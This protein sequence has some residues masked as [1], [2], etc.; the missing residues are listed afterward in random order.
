MR[1]CS[2][3]L[4]E[5]TRSRARSI[6]AVSPRAFVLVHPPPP[7][8]PAA[9]QIPPSSAHPP[10]L[11]PPRFSFPYLPHFQQFTCLI[12]LLL[13][14]SDGVLELLGR[15]LRPAGIFTPWIWCSS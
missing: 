9:C 11:A 15:V 8:S 3:S 4:L 12:S 5:C 1:R 7:S 14:N 6:S 2:R 10:R 13:T